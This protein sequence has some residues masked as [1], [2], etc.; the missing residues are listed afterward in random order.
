MKAKTCLILFILLADGEVKH[1]Q[2][3]ALLPTYDVFDEYRY[4]EPASEFNCLEYRGFRIA[5]TVCEDIWNIG[6]ENP[7]YKVCPLDILIKE[8][9]D[10]I[11]N[12]SA[13]P[14]SYSHA[15]ERLKVL[16]ANVD[17]YKVPIFYS[18][19]VGAQTELIF[20][21]GSVVISGNGKS[22]S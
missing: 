1:I 6:N 13:S 5:L 16:K 4:F 11:I 2:H 17:R 8:S 18:N 22:T 10:F 7:L 15:Q 3:K 12:V 14:F 19:N 9:P 20:D 21:G